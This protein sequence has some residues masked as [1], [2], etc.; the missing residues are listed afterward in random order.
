MEDLRFYLKAEERSQQWREPLKTLK[1]LLYR[2]CM[3]IGSVEA[4]GDQGYKNG[5]AIA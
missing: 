1:A 2:N 3:D 4:I 5:R